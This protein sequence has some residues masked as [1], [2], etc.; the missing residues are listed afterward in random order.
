MW[1]ALEKARDNNR[2]VN[3]MVGKR[4]GASLLF[5][6]FI[7]PPL[8]N[9]PGDVTAFQIFDRFSFGCFSGPQISRQVPDLTMI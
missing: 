7:L 8:Y 5:E 9:L 1:L 6:I 4:Y 3:A 2:Q